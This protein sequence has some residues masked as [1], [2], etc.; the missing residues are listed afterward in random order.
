MLQLLLEYLHQIPFWAWVTVPAIALGII[1]YYVTHHNILS[2][3]G[4]FVFYLVI[5]WGAAGFHLWVEY[6][7][8]HFIGQ[9]DDFGVPT[10]FSDPGLSVLISGWPIWIV[11]TLTVLFSV[12]LLGWLIKYIIQLI[13][14]KREGH[15]K[16]KVIGTVQSISHQFEISDLRKKLGAAEK[17]LKAVVEGDLS[18]A[19]VNQLHKLQEQLAAKKEKYG[20]LKEQYE[21]QE[22]EFQEI[23]SLAESL[24]EEHLNDDDDEDD[25]D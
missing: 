22:E 3:V 21:E 19:E 6:L 10:N 11:P 24:L 20:K 4:V 12:F 18:E 7:E 25:D 17:D 8:E 14:T 1:T 16:E 2:S 13:K 5:A 15:P 9:Y 23:R